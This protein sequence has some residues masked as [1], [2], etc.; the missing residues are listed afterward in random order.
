MLYPV[1]TC[2]ITKEKV[3]DTAL[4]YDTLANNNR[5]PVA[6]SRKR[7]YI[8]EGSA[9]WYD[10]RVSKATHVLDGI[11]FSFDSNLIFGGVL[12]ASTILG[13][14]RLIPVIACGPT[15]ITNTSPVSI[16]VGTPLSFVSPSPFMVA[17]G[18]APRMPL[19]TERVPAYRRFEESKL[20][21][22][23]DCRAHSCDFFTGDKYQLMNN[24]AP[25]VC[26]SDVLALSSAGPNQQ[27][28]VLVLP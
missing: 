9:L 1:E 13:E 25:E 4:E 19:A 16:K 2:I 21:H 11:P 5:Y 20:S 12:A 14:D 10:E 15:L 7:K 8:S 28:L 26:I 22:A 27:L 23:A 18:L 6:H 3:Y 17:D 24:H